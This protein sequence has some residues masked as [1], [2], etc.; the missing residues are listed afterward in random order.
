[1][2]IPMLVL[3]LMFAAACSAGA[4]GGPATPESR[5]D[6]QMQGEI[7][8]A[9]HALSRVNDGRN[10][11][12]ALTAIADL[13]R[14]ANGEREEL[15][16]QIAL[17]LA[18]A[19]NNEEGLAGVAL[20]D[21][22]AFTPEEKLAV[23]LPHLDHAGPTL[24]R[25]LES[26]LN[27]IDGAADGEADFRFYASVLG[28]A[29]NDATLVAYMFRVAPGE[30]LRVMMA[31]QDHGGRP[32]DDEVLALSRRVDEALARKRQ[33]ETLD[34]VTALRTRRSVEEIAL[35]QER[36]AKLYVAAVLRLAPEL[37]K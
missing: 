10:T 36:W 8:R 12:E 24:K 26:I 1:M 34:E 29:Q 7:G 14:A 19:G 31:S 32:Q 16:L 17:F 3:F 18:G 28:A 9:V 37:G 2:R 35:R 20:L 27:S 6:P 30:A 25:V 4:N 15:L 33:G 21:H 5:S 22:F 23:V 13:E 11:D